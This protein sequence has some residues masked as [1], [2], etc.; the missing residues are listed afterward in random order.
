MLVLR[1]THKGQRETPVRQILVLLICSILTG[2][3]T[4]H[5]ISGK[6]G[7]EAQSRLLKRATVLRRELAGLEA[8][9]A[10]LEGEIALLAD[11]NPD[12]DYIDELARDLLGFARPG[13]VI[14]ATG[15]D[16]H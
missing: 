5:A 8:V 11:P 9:Q 4:Y 10:R 14:I 16:A 15:G 2:Y 1:T 3:F 7:F 12:P 13:D 6:H